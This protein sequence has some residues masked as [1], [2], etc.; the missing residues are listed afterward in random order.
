MKFALCHN[1]LKIAISFTILSGTINGSAQ[2][3]NSEIDASL[4][5]IINKQTE[6]T[7]RIYSDAIEAPSEL[8]N[9]KEYEIY[10]ARSKV[11]PLLF[12]EKVRTASLITKTRRYTN[13]TLQYDTYLDEVVY[14]DTSRTINLRFPLIALNKNTIEGFNL[15]FRDDSMIFRMFRLPECAMENLGEGFYEVA[16]EDKSRYLIK[17]ASTFYVREALKNY[18]YSPKKYISTGKNFVKIKSARS[19]VNLVGDKSDDVREFLHSSGIKVRKA[20]KDQIISVL[21]YYD[22][23]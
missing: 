1:I 8:V 17:H 7:K 16:Y 6:Y 19:L 20:D 14:T 2:S 12:P 9:G 23:L 18:K 5:S 15:Y 22:S 10:Y 3:G 11:K 13:L 21:K 4:N